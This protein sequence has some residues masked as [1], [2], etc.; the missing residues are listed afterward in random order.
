MLDD[1][2]QRVG[3]EESQRGDDDDHADQQD[4]EDRSISRESPGTRRH[5]LLRDQRA[6]QRQDGNLHHEAPE[7]HH[8]RQRE[9]VEGGVG[10]ESAEGRSVVRARF[11]VRVENLRKTMR[12]RIGD[13]RQSGFGD[14]RDAGRQQN[15]RREDQ[16]EQHRELHLA[17][18]DLFT[19]VF[20][21]ATHHQSRDEDGQHRHHQHPV[22]AGTDAAEDDLADLHV[23]QRDQTAQ[24]REAVVHRVDRAA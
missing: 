6:G 3:R 12:T 2:A 17:R 8:E 13:S 20:R 18:L 15:H 22:E 9:V 7:Q 16:D 24:R 19:E 1:R 23:D 4:H 14:H 11:G 10:V 5:G 21:R